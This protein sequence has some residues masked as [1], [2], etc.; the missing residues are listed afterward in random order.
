MKDFK[1]R[2]SS[3]TPFYHSWFFIIVLGL[4]LGLFVKSAYASFNKKK[5]ADLEKEKYQEKLIDLKNKKENLENKINHLKTERGIE[6]E[7]RK[8]FNVTKEGEKI[9][10][11]I[12]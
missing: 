6:E 1:T 7:L 5:T 12:E 3:K 9:I 10:K 2:K 8:R 4:V 11:I